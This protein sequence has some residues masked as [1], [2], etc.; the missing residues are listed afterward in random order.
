MA[1]H[2]EW[3]AG[4]IEHRIKRIPQ[5]LDT[6][7]GITVA[8]AAA[9]GNEYLKE[10]APWSDRTGMARA[11]ISATYHHEK[12]KHTILFAHGVSYGIWL[13]VANS[14]RYQ[15]IM[16]TVRKTSHSL[17]RDFEHLMRKMQ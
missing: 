9:K 3:D 17:M 6:L 10:D 12:S 8:N 15:V 14:G 5:R 16:P 2:V 4:R 1:S 13:E 7:I 11:S